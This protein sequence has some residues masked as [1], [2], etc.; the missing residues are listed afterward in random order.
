VRVIRVDRDRRAGKPARERLMFD[1]VQVDSYLHRHGCL[2][3]SQI[4]A[5]TRAARAGSAWN[6]SKQVSEDPSDADPGHR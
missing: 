3:V 2:L 6:S 1:V 4:Q 5:R